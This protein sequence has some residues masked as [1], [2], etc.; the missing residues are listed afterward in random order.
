MRIHA[1][2]TVLFFCATGLAQA[3]EPPNLVGVWKGSSLAVGI[4]STPYRVPDGPGPTFYEQAQEYT[5]NFTEQ[6]GA[7][8]I[9]TLTAGKGTE[10]VLGSFQPPYFTGGIF[11]DDDGHYT[12]TMRDAT[13]MDLCYDHL[14]PKSKV[15]ACFTLKKQ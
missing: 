1:F 14:Y 8:F 7:R 3:Q 15:V 10:T 13:T 2:A 4:G 6:K 12:F 9:G 5:Y 11:I